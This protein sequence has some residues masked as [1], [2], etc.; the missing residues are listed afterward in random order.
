MINWRTLPFTF[1]KIAKWIRPL[2]VMARAIHGASS[3]GSVSAIRF[4]IW[5]VDRIMTRT[6]TFLQRI[7]SIFSRKRKVTFIP[8]QLQLCEVPNVPCTWSLQQCMPIL[9]LDRGQLHCLRCSCA[10]AEIWHWGQGKVHTNICCCIHHFVGWMTVE[11]CLLSILGLVFPS[12]MHVLSWLRASR[13]EYC[14]FAFLRL[15]NTCGV[16]PSPRTFRHFQMSP[17][18]RHSNKWHILILRDNRLQVR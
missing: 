13:A 5:E 6:G 3:W 2:H 12:W 10:W 1:L 15:V 7:Q 8:V 14:T 17:L 18:M 4:R 9:Y 11:K 16:V